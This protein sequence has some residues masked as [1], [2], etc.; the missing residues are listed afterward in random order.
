MVASLCTRRCSVCVLL[1]AVLAESFVDR[2]DTEWTYIY[3]VE[4][5]LTDSD[6]YHIS[7]CCQGRGGMTGILFLFS[8]GAHA[9]GSQPV[10]VCQFVYLKARSLKLRRVCFPLGWHCFHFLKNKEKKKNFV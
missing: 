1:I 2:C 6:R 8:C 3:P 4:K 9:L 5:V 7:T 10:T